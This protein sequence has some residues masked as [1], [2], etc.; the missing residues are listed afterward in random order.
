MQK[1]NTGN[2]SRLRRTR[3]LQNR[4]F[5]FLFIRSAA[6]IHCICCVNVF[7]CVSTTLSLTEQSELLI[8][9]E[10]KTDVGTACC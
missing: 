4:V 6:V 8:R 5:P 9:E 10:E 3:Y 7:L 2:M 1:Q